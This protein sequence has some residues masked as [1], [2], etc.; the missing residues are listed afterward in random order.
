MAIVCRGS[1][2]VLVANRSLWLACVADLKHVPLEEN[3]LPIVASVE[4]PV[5]CQSFPGI[6][7]IYVHIL[8]LRVRFRLF[9]Q[10]GLVSTLT[11]LLQDTSSDPFVLLASRALIER[12]SGR[13]EGSDSNTNSN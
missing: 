13:E 7:H 3:T 12:V 8:F 9:N 11:E 6:T 4:G 10:K 5:V 1:I 2:S